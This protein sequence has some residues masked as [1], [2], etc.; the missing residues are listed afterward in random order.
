MRLSFLL[1]EASY[2]ASGIGWGAGPGVGLPGRAPYYFFLDFYPPGLPP[3]KI[4]KKSFGL[5]L[6][7]SN[8]DNFEGLHK[9][10]KF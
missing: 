6:K 9:N 7:S 4:F 8:L 1:L 10:L 2:M 5:P 3:K